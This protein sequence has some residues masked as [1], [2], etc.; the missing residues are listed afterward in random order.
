MCSFGYYKDTNDQCTRCP[1]NANE[2]SC[3]LGPDLR[4]TCNCLS[5]YTGSSCNILGKIIFS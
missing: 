1:C 4:V 2:E 3:S 5:G